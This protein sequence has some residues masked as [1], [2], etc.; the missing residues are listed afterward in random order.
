MYVSTNIIYK[1]RANK[2]TQGQGWQ[3][4]R[5]SLGYE[6]QYVQR[7]CL[8]LRDKIKYIPSGI[9]SM[10]TKVSSK[11]NPWFWLQV[12]RRIWWRWMLELCN[13]GLLVWGVWWFGIRIGVHPGN[14]PF[15]FRW[16]Q[17]CKPPGPKPTI[18]HWPNAAVQKKL[19]WRLLE[20]GMI[21]ISQRKAPST[22]SGLHFS[23]VSSH[24]RFLVQQQI[25]LLQKK[26]PGNVI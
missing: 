15:H 12:L 24:F 7:L 2:L 20:T 11:V 9:R 26:S 14:N 3:Q 1:Y 21:S 10:A 19:N 16:F 13:Y 6:L 4:A 18:N 22:K 17:E 25:S 5:N 8:Q 23:T